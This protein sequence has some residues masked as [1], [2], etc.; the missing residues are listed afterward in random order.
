MPRSSRAFISYSHDSPEHKDRVLRFA[1]RLVT[2]GIDVKLD[3]WVDEPEGGWPFWTERQIADSDFVILVC[4]NTLRERVEQPDKG[5]ESGAGVFWEVNV[6]RTCLYNA[7]GSDRR[8]MPAFFGDSGQEAIPE[9]LQGATRY[10]I[11][12]PEGYTALY[13]RLTDQPEIERPE[14]GALVV[15][16]RKNLSDGGAKDATRIRENEF[17]LSVALSF[18][19]LSPLANCDEKELRSIEGSISTFIRFDNYRTEDVFLYWLNY[20]GAR[21]YYAKVQAGRSHL[22]QTYVTHP[23]VVTKADAS[24]GMATCLAIFE[25]AGDPGVAEIK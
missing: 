12:S 16:P 22:Q 23:W 24:S 13:R 14:L 4:T 25:P 8:F 21:V 5:V 1:S 7:K 2:E 20:E 17:S 19:K 15:L 6:I 10:Q 3:Q 11:D 18:K 9:I